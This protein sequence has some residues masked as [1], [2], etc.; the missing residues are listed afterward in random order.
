MKK[1][2]IIIAFLLILSILPAFGRLQAPK[3]LPSNMAF[4]SVDMCSDTDGGINPYVYGECTKDG[5]KLVDSCVTPSSG[6]VDSYIVNEQY[7]GITCKTTAMVCDSGYW[8]ENGACKTVYDV[9]TLHGI[10][11]PLGENPVLHVGDMLP[12]FF[13][14]SDPSGGHMPAFSEGCKSDDPGGMGNICNDP[15][16]LDLGENT[17]CNSGVLAYPNEPSICYFRVGF[18]DIGEH[19]LYGYTCNT[20][21]C[22]ENFVDFNFT[23]EGKE[24]IYISYYDK[25]KENLKMAKINN[26]DSVSIETI[27]SNFGVGAFNSIILDSNGNPHVSYF[28]SGKTVKY[29][30]YVRTGGNCDTDGE[31]DCETIDGSIGPYANTQFDVG[32][33]TTILLDGNELPQIIVNNDKQDGPF[34]EYWKRL[35]AVGYSCDEWSCEWITQFITA[36]NSAGSMINSLSD[37]FPMVVYIS[38]NPDKN[39]IGLAQRW[40]GSPSTTCNNSPSWDCLSIIKLN[41][42]GGFGGINMIKDSL[43]VAVFEQ[44]RKN[45]WYMEEVGYGGKCGPTN[46]DWNCDVIDTGIDNSYDGN[47]EIF[48]IGIA[49]SAGRTYLTYYDGTTG[50][51]KVAYNSGL[52]NCGPDNSWQCDKLDYVGDVNSLHADDFGS[53]IAYSEISDRFYVAYKDAVKGNLKLAYNVRDGG[54]CGQGKWECMTIDN[55]GDVGGYPDIVT[56]NN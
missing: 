48:R 15:N 23:V 24:I 16:Q 27:D 7:C 28:D 55:D 31:W 18:E 50:H 8:C 29:A 2:V 52:G 1:L 17:W 3:Q 4:N 46:V 32:E 21:G 49:H 42:G 45:I 10:T 54:N 37:E 47:A 11:S 39:R 13:N 14:W 35:G 9:P 26:V 20:Y 44:D 33:Y 5:S 30:K 51:L 43:K 40:P 38:D 56:W 41:N 53:S 12:L 36:D 6:A 19:T 34:L 25:T 22:S